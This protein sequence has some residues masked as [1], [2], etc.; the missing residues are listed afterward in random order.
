[1]DS[2]AAPPE[3]GAQRCGK[4]DVVRPRKQVNSYLQKSMAPDVRRSPKPANRRSGDQRPVVIRP[5]EVTTTQRPS[6]LRIASTRPSPG[7]RSPCS[8][9]ILP[10]L[11]SIRAVP[12]WTSRTTQ[13]ATPDFGGGCSGS[14]ARDGE[15]GA[16]EPVA[17]LGCAPPAPRAMGSSI[18]AG[19]GG[20]VVA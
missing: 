11:P 2:S 17:Y 10:I 16:A 1:M 14:F 7:T 6:C 19:L 13:P 3:G 5:L 4:A 9:S 8:T 20:L 18:S 12:R 15:D